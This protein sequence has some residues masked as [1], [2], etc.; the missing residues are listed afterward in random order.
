MRD[1]TSSAEDRDGYVVADGAGIKGTNI[2][3]SLFIKGSQEGIKMNLSLFGEQQY[4]IIMGP[5]YYH[6]IN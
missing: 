1:D 5:F 2:C 6:K 3:V 4:E